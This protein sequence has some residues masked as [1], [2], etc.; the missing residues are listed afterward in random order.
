MVVLKN[1][2]GSGW[3]AME[4]PYTIASLA[5][6]LDQEN[7]RTQASPVHSIRESKKRKRHE[8]A[9]AVDGEGIFLYNVW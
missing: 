2:R 3:A 6:P 7:G 4:A 5:K 1:R 8:V 9:V